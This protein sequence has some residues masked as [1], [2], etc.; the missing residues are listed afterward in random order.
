MFKILTIPFSY[1]YLIL[2]FNL[3]LPSG[4]W[5]C[6][7]VCLCSPGWPQSPCIAETRFVLLILLPQPFK[8]QDYKRV[9]TYQVSSW[10]IRICLLLSLLSWL[11]PGH[12]SS[13]PEACQH[14]DNGIEISCLSLQILGSPISHVFLDCTECHRVGQLGATICLHTTLLVLAP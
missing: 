6:L 1:C 13:S 5:F 14:G 3:L 12:P 7:F 4:A 8:C 11:R 9:L 10:K 2:I